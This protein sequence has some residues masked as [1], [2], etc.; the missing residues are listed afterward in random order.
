MENQINKTDRHDV[1]TRRGNPFNPEQPKGIMNIPNGTILEKDEEDFLINYISPGKTTRNELYESCLTEK[2]KQLL[3]T[4]SKT[5]KSTMKMG[6]KKVYD[7]TKQTAKFLRHINYARLRNFDLKILMCYEVPPTCFY[8]RKRGL[9]RNPIKSE[10]TTELKSMIT[11]N[12]PT[13][14][15]PVHHHRNVI[16]NFMTYILEKC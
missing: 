13:Y 9:I 1:A 5:K 2:N 15:R 11:K 4:I 7:L 8:L 12:I 3:E 16:I 14:L 6:E 10:L